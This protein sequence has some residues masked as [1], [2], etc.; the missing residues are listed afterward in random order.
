MTQLRPRAAVARPPFNASGAGSIPAGPQSPELLRFADA[1][2]RKQ[3][4]P[5]CGQTLAGDEGV[6][7]AVMLAP[8]RM[9]GDDSARSSVFKHLFADVAGMSARR[10]WVIVLPPMQIRP[11]A[12]RA[13]SASKEVGGQIRMSTCGGTL[14]ATPAIAAISCSSAFS[15]VP[16]SGNQ[17]PHVDLLQRIM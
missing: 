17:P 16:I 3:S 6:G 4:R 1:E 14:A 2:D 12:V 10:F 9:S 15:Y 8:L 11:L 5:P 13:A 7:L